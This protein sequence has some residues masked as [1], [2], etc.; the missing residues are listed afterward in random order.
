MM[1]VDIVFRHLSIAG[2]DE[3]CDVACKGSSIVKIG[4]KLAVSAPKGF[5][6]ACDG[7]LVSPPFIDPHQ[8]LDCAYMMDHE[9]QSGTLEEAVDLF[10]SIKRTR[11][12]ETVK[13]LARRA[14]IESMYNGV[15]Y[16]RSQVDVDSIVG[17]NHLLPILEL[18]REYQGIVDIQVV[19]CMEYS[20][21]QEPQ[22]EGY[23]REA[24]EAG[25]DMVGG[26]PHME[27]TVDAM[28][29]HCQMVFN[30]ARSFNVDVDMHV[31]EVLDPNCRTLE[32]IADM[33]IKEGY[34][35]RVTAGHCCALSAYDDKYA[36]QVI[37]KVAQAGIHVITNPFTNLYI[38]GRR[39]KTPIWRG[40][41]RV[42]ELIESG[43]NV[44]C[45]L[46]DIRNLFN[47]FGKMN[48]LEVALFTSLVAQM[49]TP[50]QLRQVFDMPRYNA[51]KILGIRDYGINDGYPADFV[52]L[53]VI[54]ILD[55]IRLAPAP[56]YVIRNGKIIAE[57]RTE[58]QSYL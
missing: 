58:R 32:M 47:P 3:I 53:P 48:M 15:T 26:I 4:K 12:K 1:P 29:K 50:E 56:R 8:H 35:R 44:S 54:S 31:D 42:K 9:N 34:Q 28:Y 40:I 25:A 55:A 21:A 49:T 19:A 30:V 33:T 41:T 37:K 38:Q 14:I 17:M 46:D 27:A 13:E 6:I 5:D 43:V 36:E 18:K 51:A 45:G 52:I 23:L 7:M 24:I 20:L 2:K 39:D 11:S 22:A 16:I 10:T 57:N